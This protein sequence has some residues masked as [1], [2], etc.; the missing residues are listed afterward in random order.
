M[1]RPV[2]YLSAW[3]LALVMAAGC[4]LGGAEY[5][6]SPN[7]CDANADCPAGFCDIERNM[8]L[9][10]KEANYQ[11]FLTVT[12]TESSLANPTTSLVT[13]PLDVEAGAATTALD[14]RVPRTVALTAFIEQD[15][16]PIKAE[17]RLSRRPSLVGEDPAII[18]GTTLDEPFNAEDG[19]LANFSARVLRGHTYDVSIFPQ[20]ERVTDLPPI[21][22]VV[23]V[24]QDA[25][26]VRIEGVGYPM[27]LGMIRGR[28]RDLRSAAIASIVVRAID[29]I[30][31]LVVSSKATTDVQGNFVL[32]H[33]LG[34]QP[35]L[36]Q[37]QAEGSDAAVP[38]FIV[39]PTTLI[40]AAEGEKIVV[41]PEL[42]RTPLDLKVVDDEGKAVEG[43]V[44]TAASREL[45]LLETNMQGRFSTSQTTGVDGS[46]KLPLFAGEYDFTVTPPSP[47]EGTSRLAVAEFSL[48]VKEP[49]THEQRLMERFVVQG[50]V[51]RYDQEPMAGVQ[52]EALS[53]VSTDAEYRAHRSNQAN[54]DEYGSFSMLLDKGRY[55]LV[56]RPPQNSGLSWS[57]RPKFEV[58]MRNPTMPHIE[59][60]PPVAIH[61]RVT[62]ED[63]EPVIGAAVRAYALLREGNETRSILIGRADTNEA[64]EFEI[65]LPPEI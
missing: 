26:F 47:E 41:V 8:C 51:V 16:R 58:L 35:Y 29:P 46:T 24:P 59:L 17:V 50:S 54:V 64:G 55:D 42:S 23:A 12:P 21:R 60:V 61:G 19:E 13:E 38:V 62:S 4:S 33:M 2:S 27:E 30:T 14:L 49:M 5:Y 31:Q 43:A 53:R 34:N 40:T 48:R 39:D 36:L 11:V 1:S 10:E 28:V 6:L 52:I 63:F 25:T 44:V 57:V 20:G 18:T 65:L 9:S 37:L 22:L 15:R 32:H 45:D 7:F 3:M 56:T